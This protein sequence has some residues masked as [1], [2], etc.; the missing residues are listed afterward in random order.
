MASDDWETIFDS[1]T[2]EELA[3]QRSFLLAELKNLY[4]SQS[5]G[6]KSYSRSITDVRLRLAALTRVQNA[7]GRRY[8]DEATAADFS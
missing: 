3:D 2:G 6:G 4:L 7:R 8:S 1:M 5:V